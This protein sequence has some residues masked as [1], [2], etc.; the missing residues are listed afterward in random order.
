MK[1]YV[2]NPIVK[3]RGFCKCKQIKGGYSPLLVQP[4]P[5]A[6][7]GAGMKSPDMT[8]VKSVLSGLQT[9]NPRKKYISI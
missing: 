3:G 9:T 1:L 4:A 6:L 7:S 2:V 5:T 8:K